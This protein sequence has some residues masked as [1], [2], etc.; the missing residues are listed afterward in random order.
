MPFR[1]LAMRQ[2]CRTAQKTAPSP[3][4]LHIR[5][6]DSGSS[7]GARFSIGSGARRQ[8]AIRTT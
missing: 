4:N 2:K 7:I 3:S 8:L 6:P 1:I 5:A